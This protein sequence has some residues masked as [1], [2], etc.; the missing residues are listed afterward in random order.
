VD[1][2]VEEFGRSDILVNNAALQTAQPD[3]IVDITTSGAP[4]QV[5]ELARDERGEGG[6]LQASV[7]DLLPPPQDASVRSG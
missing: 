4:Q 1:Q 6:F 3:G 7:S 5:A 2:T